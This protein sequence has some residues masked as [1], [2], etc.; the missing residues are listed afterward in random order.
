MFRGLFLAKPSD[1][2]DYCMELTS[3]KR[4]RYLPVLGNNIFIYAYKF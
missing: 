1:D 4:I 3:A 2:L